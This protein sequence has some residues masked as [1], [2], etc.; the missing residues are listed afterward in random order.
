V[1]LVDADGHGL[2]TRGVPAVLQDRDTLPA[3][4]AGQAHWPSLREAIYD[5]ALTAERCEAWSN[6]HGMRHVVVAR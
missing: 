4:D 5:G 2:A 1:A 6:R 3:L